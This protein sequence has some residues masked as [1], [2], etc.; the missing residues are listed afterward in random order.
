M[1]IAN[2]FNNYFTGI[3][4]TIAQGIQYDGN[5]DYSYYLKNKLTLFLDLRM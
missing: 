3:G 1:D 5:K 2:K 4:Q